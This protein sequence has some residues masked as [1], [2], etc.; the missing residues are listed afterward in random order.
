MI[1][2]WVAAADLVPER[3]IAAGPAS[4]IWRERFGSD[5][6]LTNDPDAVHGMACVLSGTGWA[7]DLEHRARV[8]AARAGIRSVAVIDHW[9]NYAMRFER[10]GEMQLPDAIWVGD[11]EAAAIARAEF[12]DVPVETH[13]NLYL[14][15]QAREAG[16]VPDNGDALFLLEPARS[17]WGEGV[18]GEFQS[19]DYFVARREAAGVP[20]GTT[21]RIRPHPSDP[22]GKYDEWIAAHPGT[23]LDTSPDMGTALSDARWVIGMNSAGLAIALKAGRCV[24]S[25][26][27]PHAPPCVL[28]HAAIARLCNL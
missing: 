9:V 24:I 20:T 23:S 15:E 21:V 14:S 18:P 16:P 19:L 1:A 27:P 8:A 26:L 5:V 25:A 12:A 13:S 22:P 7:S 17:D 2:A 4:K 10:E 3:V 6:A 28:P 11:A